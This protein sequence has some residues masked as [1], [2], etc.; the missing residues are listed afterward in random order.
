MILIMGL[1]QTVKE[2]PEKM[3][4]SALDKKRPGVLVLN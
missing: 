3:A 4:F 2:K 1:V